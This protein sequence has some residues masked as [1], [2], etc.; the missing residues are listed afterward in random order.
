MIIVNAYIK[1]AISKKIKMMM[2]KM[3][4]IHTERQ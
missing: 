1:E 2:I 4:Y 3:V